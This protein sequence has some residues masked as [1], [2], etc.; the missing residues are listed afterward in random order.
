[1]RSRGGRHGGRARKRRPRT[2]R[3]PSGSRFPIFRK[4]RSPDG[5]TKSAAPVAPAERESAEVY[6][7]AKG[8]NF[9]DQPPWKRII[10]L[11]AGA[12]MNHS[13]ALVLIIVMFTCVGRPLYT[14]VYI[15]PKDPDSQTTAEATESDPYEDPLGLCTGDTIFRW[16]EKKFILS[17]ILS[18]RWAVKKQGEVV[19]VGVYRND[20]AGER[21]KI[22]L[23]I[24]LKRTQIS[25]TCR[26]RT[27]F[28]LRWDKKRLC[29]DGGRP[30]NR[31]SLRRSAIRCVFGKARRVSSAF[32]GGIADGEN[33]PDEHGR[34]C[35]DD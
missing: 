19:R 24:S 35:D 25:K 7:E 22:W 17:R 18:T 28:L 23:D 16:R 33:G 1:M 10:V 29:V 31:I 13:L 15:P 8:E 5:V 9:N 27:R 6:P 34:A 11:I 3:S 14:M 4:Q 26:I 20:A 12:T 21:K 32:A 2:A 30:S